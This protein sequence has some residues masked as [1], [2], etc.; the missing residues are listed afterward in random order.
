ML[1][2]NFMLYLSKIETNFLKLTLVN[3]GAMSNVACIH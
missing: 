1:P 2:V 3:T